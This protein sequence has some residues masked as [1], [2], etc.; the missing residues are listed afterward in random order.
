MEKKE[1]MMMQGWEVS[2]GHI[3]NMKEPG[4]YLPVQREWGKVF[5]LESDI[6]RNS[7]SYFWWLDSL[8]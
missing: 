2:R 7:E 1:A 6:T 3:T 5:K 4:L 8:G